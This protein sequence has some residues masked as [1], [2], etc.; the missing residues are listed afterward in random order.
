MDIEKGKV[1]SAVCDRTWDMLNNK[2]LPVYVSGFVVGAGDPPPTDRPTDVPRT[3]VYKVQKDDGAFVNVSYMGYPPSPVGD[4]YRAKVTLDFYAGSIQVGDRIDASG[5]LDR[6]TNTVVV[7]NQ[8]DYIRTSVP[9]KEVVGQVLS[10]GDTTA[11]NGPQDAPRTFVYIIQKDDGTLINVNYTAYP[12]SP[13]G[14][15]NL[16]KSLSASTMVG[17]KPVII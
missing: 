8:G 13:A 11:A 3:F 5:L 7:A 12:P 4:A 15:A 10:G 14:D 1:A 17:S 16:V 2:D 6:E 9:K